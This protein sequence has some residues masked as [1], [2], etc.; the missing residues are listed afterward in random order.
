M[1]PRAIRWS[2]TAFFVTLSLEAHAYRPFDGTDA[3]VA[4]VGDLELE[5]GPVQWLSEGSGHFLVVP[6]T[7]LNLGVLPRWELVSS[8]QNVVGLDAAPRD[9]LVDADLVL[10]HVVVEGSLQDAGSGPSV[11]V[12]FG[13]LLPNVNGEERGYGA[14]VNTIVS[15]HWKGFSLHAN[16]WLKLTRGNLHVDWYEGIILEGSLEA[17]VRPVGEFFVEHEWSGGVT[18]WS[19]LVGGIWRARDGLDLDVGLREARIG[20]ERAAE[21]RIGLTWTLGLWRP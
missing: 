6:S 9:Q 20:D 15:E 11:A 10:K 13:A 17:P 16:S 12:E 14:S 8:F 3:G 2:A 1:R 18:T 7:V 19:A 5:L 21:V 4:E